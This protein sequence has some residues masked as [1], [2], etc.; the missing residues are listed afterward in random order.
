MNDRLYQEL[1][2]LR[3]RENFR[4]LS[5]LVNKI[6]EDRLIDSGVNL[7]SKIYQSDF[8]CLLAKLEAIQNRIAKIE[9]SQNQNRDREK[10]THESDLPG[11]SEILESIQNRIA[12]IERDLFENNLKIQQIISDTLLD[13]AISS[14]EVREEA[15]KKIK[16]M[17]AE[18]TINYFNQKNKKP[19]RDKANGFR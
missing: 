16:E 11:G 4:S 2:L 10:V 9:Q 19:K 5:S 17:V 3:E 1:E 14:N 18:E 12:K 6:I 13:L 8:D 15:I 7:E